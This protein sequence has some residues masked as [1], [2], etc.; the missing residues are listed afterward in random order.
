MRPT[1]SRTA[2]SIALI[3]DYQGGNR[4]ALDR[5]VERYYDRVV[6]IVRSRMG[7]WLREVE[8]VEDLV[9]ETFL[10]AV[11]EFDRFEI[12]EERAL[13]HWLAKLA[14]RR[15]LNAARHH[16]RAKRDH[17]RVVRLPSPSPGSRSSMMPWHL[18]ANTTAIPDRVARS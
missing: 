14:E 16:R 5:L 6:P 10:A 3:R 13:I 18:A 12:R 7:P 1:D 11:R 17:R 2:D 15:I 8:S 4:A 9:Q